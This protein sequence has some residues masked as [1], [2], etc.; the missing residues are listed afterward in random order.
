MNKKNTIDYIRPC[1]AFPQT[2]KVWKEYE[3]QWEE[4]HD[5]EYWRIVKEVCEDIAAGD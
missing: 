1:G 3:D 4:K 2:P 5:A